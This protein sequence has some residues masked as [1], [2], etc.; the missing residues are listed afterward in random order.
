VAVSGRGPGRRPGTSDTRGAILAAARTSFA[1]KGFERTT[2]RGV[3]SAAGVAPG[4][5]HHFF[6]AKDDLFLAALAVPFDPRRM[7]APAVDGPRSRLGERLARTVLHT[8]EDEVR[9][10]SLVAF[11]RAAMTSPEVAAVLRTGMP[12][13]ALGVLREVVTGPD[14]AVRVEL[15]FSQLVGVALVR[16]VLA[17]EPVASLPVDELVVRLAPVLQQHLLGARRG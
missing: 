2:M 4:L 7:L 16:Y 17:V 6:G 11:L 1:D 12:V 9:R 13:I 15:A 3:A 10:E 8:W 5:V 14:A